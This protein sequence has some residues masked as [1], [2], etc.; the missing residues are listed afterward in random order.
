MPPEGNFICQTARVIPI[1]RL[2]A[3][4]G[5]RAL[6]VLGVLFAHVGYY[7]APGGFRGVDVFFVLS[8]FLITRILAS[9]REQHGSISLSRFHARRALR[10]YP[11]LMSAVLLC[12]IFYRTLYGSIGSWWQ[13]A[14][15]SLTY[16]MDI[17]R[18][19]GWRPPQA[20][21]P[22][23]VTWTLGV[24]EHFYLLWP[25]V[26]ALLLSRLGRRAAGLLSWVIAGLSWLALFVVASN[27]GNPDE[28]FYRPDL[29]AAGLFVGSAV[30]L[31]G[32]RVPVR[33]LPGASA[34]SLLLIVSLLQAGGSVSIP[35]TYELKLP[36]VWLAT[37]TLLQ[38]SSLRLPG[39][40]LR[41]LS[42]A[43]LAYVGR[44]SYGIYVYHLALLGLISAQ[45]LRFAIRMPLFVL[46]PIAVAA[47][48][49][50]YVE[51][52]FLRLK[53]RRFAGVA[54]PVGVG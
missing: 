53:E 4:D 51:L 32:L 5:L 13:E 7:I 54:K 26:L 6:A 37:A 38:T 24:E 3:L 17:A 44:I 19:T 35:L 27:G 8:G 34:V 47:L 50:R 36:L 1:G 18:A 41:I 25:L 39:W 11:A 33:V 30:A 23:A 52:P 2:D 14:W 31:T 40:A 42:L 16:L 48:S 46:V 20:A 28:I 12:L 10:L 45:S 29:R 43:P 15:L 9:E 21:G 49:F 22:L